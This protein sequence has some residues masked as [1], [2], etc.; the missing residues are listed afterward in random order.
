VAAIDLLSDD[1]ACTPGVYQSGTV[2]PR[3]EGGDLIIANQIRS[4]G[5]GSVRL[6]C[7][8]VQRLA[9]LICVV[10]LRT[11]DQDLPLLFRS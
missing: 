10:R 7:V 1:L 3:L 2:D 8:P 9:A 4:V 5:S 11:R 6:C